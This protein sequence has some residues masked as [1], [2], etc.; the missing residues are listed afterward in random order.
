MKKYFSF[1]SLRFVMGLQYR[2]AAWAGV[3]TQFVWGGMMIAMYQAFYQTEP[4][5]FPMTF[6]AA[7]RY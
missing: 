7:A 3:A 5:Q 2:A 6:E 1:F 4:E